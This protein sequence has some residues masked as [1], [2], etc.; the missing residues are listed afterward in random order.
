MEKYHFNRNEAIRKL[1]KAN[2][3][4]GK[5]FKNLQAERP[6]RVRRLKWLGPEVRGSLIKPS[7]LND[8]AN[9]ALAS[10]SR[11]ILRGRMSLN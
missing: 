8:R 11:N 2:G 9:H 3:S 6:K 7:L 5:E 1:K 10:G 4:L